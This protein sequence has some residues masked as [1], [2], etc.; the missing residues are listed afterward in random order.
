MSKISAV[1]VTYN[2]RKYIEKCLNSLMGSSIAIEI[3]VLD[4]ASSDGT[5]EFI[6]A[7]YPEVILFELSDNLGF[8]KGNNIGIKYAYDHGAEHIL[9]LNQDAYLESDCLQTLIAMQRNRPEYGV[10]S[11]LHLRGDAAKLDSRFALFVARSHDSDD[12]FSN[13]LVNKTIKD[14][15]QV[16]FVNAAVWLLSRSCLEKVGLFSPSFDH[17]GEDVDFA[18]RL[19]YFGLKIGVVPAARAVHDRLQNDTEISEL[20]HIQLM[21]A[22]LIRRASRVDL[23]FTH[24][25]L[26]ILYF[27]IITPFAKR[28]S[29]F[30]QFWMKT[31]HII[32]ASVR[33]SLWKMNRLEA[34]NGGLC[35]F[36][37]AERD[38]L[39]Y[40][41][42]KST[43]RRSSSL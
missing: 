21:R 18:K 37:N 12:L 16:E 20:K 39:R 8:G 1:V 5:V 27:L 7:G 43:D 11:P 9:L 22:E 30:R 19:N 42:A 4:N 25:M 33:L 40:I 14:I 6:K 34:Q 38:S 17:Y 24:N 3:L 23:P 36:S 10:L 31:S 26:S 2:G 32:Y 15:Y 35:F 41:E 29:V 13:F 28:N